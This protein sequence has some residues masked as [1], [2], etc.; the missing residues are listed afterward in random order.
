MNQTQLGQGKEGGSGVKKSRGGDEAVPFFAEALS[1][2][3]AF[4][5]ETLLPLSLLL[6]ILD[7]KKRCVSAS[8]G[9]TRS[10]GVSRNMEETISLNAA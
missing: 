1:S 10:E 3:F 9:L 2:F 6:H 8:S 4:M 5:D 7:C